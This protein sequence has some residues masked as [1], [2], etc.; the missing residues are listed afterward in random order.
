MA[1]M[2][3][4]KLWGGYKYLHFSL[5][6]A[7]I[8]FIT[9]MSFNMHLTPILRC[10]QVFVLEKQNLFLDFNV[11]VEMYVKFSWRII[12]WR[13]LRNKNISYAGWRGNFEKMLSLHQAKLIFGKIQRVEIRVWQIEMMSICQL[14]SRLGSTCTLVLGYVSFAHEA[15]V[16]KP[17]PHRIQFPILSWVAYH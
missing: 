3:P 7:G 17:H 6:Q 5:L 4:W 14:Y 10:L 9:K 15:T 8:T 11:S 1:T 16:A 12:L 2:K 13:W